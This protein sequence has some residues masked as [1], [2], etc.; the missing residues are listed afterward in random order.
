[1]MTN[2]K[3]MVLIE[4]LGECWHEIEPRQNFRF[5]ESFKFCDTCETHFPP[6]EAGNHINRDFTPCQ[7][8]H[9]LA[10][11]ISEKGEWSTFRLFYTK[12][13]LGRNRDEYLSEW[14][15]TL[16]T[17]EFCELVCKWLERKK[18]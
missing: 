16:H 15:L 3:R 7:D 2:E 12:V 10:K 14:L 11:K 17:E 9:D 5:A 6:E 4:Y 1:M 13:Y 8:A 18:K